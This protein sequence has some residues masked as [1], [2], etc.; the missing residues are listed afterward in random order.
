[1]KADETAGWRYVVGG[2]EITAMTALAPTASHRGVEAERGGKTAMDAAGA[3]GRGWV[4]Q[5]SLQCRSSA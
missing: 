4:K 5:I 3:G 2:P 1:M